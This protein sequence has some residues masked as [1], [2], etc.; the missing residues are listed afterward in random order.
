MTDNT[1]IAVIASVIVSVMGMITA[2]L[3]PFLLAWMTDRRLNDIQRT[4]DLTHAA[5][6]GSMTT[7]LRIAA[8]ALGRVAELTKHADD[9]AA[10]DLALKALQEHESQVKQNLL[11]QRK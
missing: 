3:G 11:N 4:G 10:A 2:V 5:V 7:Q 6:N 1:N 8:I 9:V